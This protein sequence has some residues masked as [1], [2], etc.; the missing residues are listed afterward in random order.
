[1]EE[2]KDKDIIILAKKID[3]TIDM[4]LNENMPAEYYY[5]VILS[6]INIFVKSSNKDIDS[7]IE[8]LKLDYINYYGSGADKSE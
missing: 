8:S 5:R 4:K 7:F 1:M 6:I 3:D 2:L